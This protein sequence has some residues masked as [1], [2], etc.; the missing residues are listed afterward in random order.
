M[1]LTLSAR[2]KMKVGDHIYY[3]N[4]LGDT[5]PG[6]ILEIQSRIKIKINYSDD[7]PYKIIRVKQSNIK[8]QSEN[9]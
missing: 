6:V 5:F 1:K 8:V 2:K 9:P 3:Q 7:E 4:K